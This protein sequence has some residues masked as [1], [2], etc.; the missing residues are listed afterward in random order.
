LSDAF[1]RH[2]AQVSAKPMSW[3]TVTYRVRASP[4]GID[5]IARGLALEQSVELPLDAIH[6][7][8]VLENVVGKVR[9]IRSVDEGLHE[10]TVALATATTGCDAAQTINMLFGNSSLHDNVEL[11]DVEFPADFIARFPGPRFGIEGLRTELDVPKRA[12][13]CAALKPQGLPPERL[14][15]L[16]YTLARAGIDVIKDDHGLADQSYAP[17]QARVAAC[18]LAIERARQDTGRRSLYA[19]SLVGSPSALLQQSRFLRDEGVAMALVAPALIGMP[20]FAELVA[21]QLEIPVMAHPAYAGAA[22]VAPSFLLGKWFRL[23]GADAVIFPHFGGRFAYSERTCAAIADTS[24]APWPGVRS[25]MPVPA[26]GIRLERA[27][28]VLEFY[29]PD[30]MLLIG[31]SLLAAGQEISAR[32]RAF[33][34]LVASQGAHAAR[35]QL[36]GKSR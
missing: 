17:F 28:E 13:T 22:R 24:R 31:G 21:D 12:L 10:V 36:I 4:H 16:C 6:D 11:A 15:D 3:I 5:A 19:P 29:G 8:F 23:L 9:G 34:D 2:E 27:R 18:Q 30:V 32:A 33:A 7:A 35:G 14:A 1:N 20:V 26:G 25:S